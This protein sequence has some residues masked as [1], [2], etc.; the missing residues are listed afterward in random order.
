MPHNLQNRLGLLCSPSLNLIQIFRMFLEGTAFSTKLY[1]HVRRFVG[2]QHLMQSYLERNRVVRYKQSNSTYIARLTS[3][4]SL[5][6]TLTSIMFEQMLAEEIATW[7]DPKGEW[8]VQTPAQEDVEFRAPM[9]CNSGEL[10]KNMTLE[11][12]YLL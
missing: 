12:S 5:A 7:L 3:R 11:L 2:S 10:P 9:L 8:F 4:V 1:H 6:K